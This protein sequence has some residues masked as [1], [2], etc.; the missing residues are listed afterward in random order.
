LQLQGCSRTWIDAIGLRTEADAALLRDMGVR[1]SRSSIPV[2]QTFEAVQA[3]LLDLRNAKIAVQGCGKR[4]VLPAAV[5]HGQLHTQRAGPELNREHGFKGVRPDARDASLSV[6]R[7]EIC[8]PSS[9][10]GRAS[11]CQWLRRAKPC[12]TKGPR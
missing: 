3:G 12:L 10:N 6:R 8:T 7:K 4:Q 2:A 9:P 11:A 1:L 5:M